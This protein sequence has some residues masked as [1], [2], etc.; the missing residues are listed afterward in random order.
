LKPHEIQVGILKRLRGTPIAR[1]TEA[2]AMRYNPDAPYNVLRTDRIDFHDMQRVVR[3]AR[4]WEMVGNSGRFRRALSLLLG[5]AP[6][7]RFMRFSDWLFATTGKTHE[8]ALERVF[9]HVHLFLTRELGVPTDVVTT[10]LVEDYESSGARG[11]LSFTPRD[12][13][14]P[15][16]VAA[17]RTLRQVRHLQR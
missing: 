14:Q 10:A 2:H 3:F 5:S 17:V 8:M 4:Y 12:H 1:H 16:P 6:Y 9:E 15:R 11:R 13:V 7:I